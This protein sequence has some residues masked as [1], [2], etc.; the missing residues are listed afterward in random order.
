MEDTSFTVTLP[1]NSNMASHPSNR[2]NNYVVKLSSPLNFSGSTLNED[3][4]WEVALT[5]VQYTNRFYDLRENSTLYVVL[6]L[7]TTGVI[8]NNVEKPKGVTELQAK[9]T[10]T[11]LADLNDTE[12]RILKSFQAA[13][14]KPIGGS[15]RTVTSYV[16]GKVLA[17]AGDYKNPL[18]VVQNL[19][20]GCNMLFGGARYLSNMG[21]AVDGATGR[22]TF[23]IDNLQLGLYMFTDSVPLVHALGLSPKAIDK[24]DPTVYN[25]NIVGTKTPRF[26]TIHSLYVY[27][28]IV[29]EQRVGDTMAPLLEIIPVR[30]VPGNRIHFSVNPL[31]YL[32]V[33]RD[34]IDSI[35]IVIMDE[36]GNVVVFPDDVENVVCR[37]RFRHVRQHF[38][39]M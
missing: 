15:T 34:Y 19:V 36:Y 21:I 4:S 38:M 6:E 5:T 7:Y 23:R 25:L 12:K 29:K 22:V 33:N 37:L 1:S 17:P 10:D 39:P 31:T 20:S 35:N 18:L 27:S 9:F 28:D 13:T 8:N 16:Y 26:D 11:N 2:G 32:P 14:H 30:G 3:V 24:R